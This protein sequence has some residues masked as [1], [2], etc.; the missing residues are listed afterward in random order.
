MTNNKGDIG[1]Y[2]YEEPHLTLNEGSKVKPEV[3]SPQIFKFVAITSNP[4]ELDQNV[5]LVRIG[6]YRYEEPHLTLKEGSKVKSETSKKFGAHVFLYVV[7]TSISSM[8]NNKGDI[9]S[10]KFG[11]LRFSNS[12]P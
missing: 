1:H 4:I 6:H 5:T 11:H 9:G 10:F 8:T 2:R 3:W 7:F 12:L